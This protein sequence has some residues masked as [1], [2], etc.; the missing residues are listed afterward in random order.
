MSTA[1]HP[2]LPRLSLNVGVTGHR[3][4]DL[5]DTNLDT[6]RE[7]IRE[8]LEFLREFA[9]N[10]SEAENYYANPQK[11]MLRAISALAEG[12]DRHVAHQA[13]ALG[14]E[15]QCPL[16]FDRE[17]YAK[18]FDTEG[19]VLE[20]DT[21]LQHKNTTAVLELDG[22]RE[23]EADSYLAAGRVVLGQSDVLLTV[24]NG[25]VRNKKGGTSQIVAEA[26]QRNLPT[27]WINSDAPHNVYLRISDGKW[28][29]WAVGAGSLVIWLEAL[30][31]PPSRSKEDEDATTLFTDYFSEVQHVYNR[32]W[33]WLPFRNLCADGRWTLP[34]FLLPDFNQSGRDEWQQ[35]PEVA[36]TFSKETVQIMDA[37]NLFEHYG[38][39]DGLAGYY[40]NL[41][42]SAFV[43]NYLLGAVAVLF[44]F[45]HF[46][47]KEHHSID[48]MFTALELAALGSVAVIY[49]FGTK[50]RWHER[51]V[52]YRLL[53]EY[54]RQLFFL[55]PL[56]PGELSSPHIPAHMAAGDPRT[57]WM[58]W[59]YRAVRRDLG[60]I[61][62]RF[63]SAYL[64]SIRTFLGSKSLIG[65]QVEYH[66]NNARRFERLDRRFVWWIKS[67][68]VFA[69][70][71][72]VMALFPEKIA[73]WIRRLLPLSTLDGVVIVLAAIATVSP[74]VGAALAGI[75]SQGEFERVRKR[76]KAM[77]HWLKHI[78]DRLKAP[79]AGSAPTSS[80]AL[81]M[82]VAEAGQLM[83]DELL[84]WRIVFKDRPLP[85]PE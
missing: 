74:A 65:G 57:T 73:G 63:S 15:L 17:E 38:W 85:E 66:E 60:I 30:F 43:V 70:L 13:L 78:A 12:S 56:G 31:R 49:R 25:E 8:V 22:S 3:P 5:T 29:P 59:H 79:T 16:P 76:S 2:P 26:R 72:A 10:L 46:A 32:G 21:L 84:D 82:V 45:L 9:G 54:L 42:R 68:F 41:Y 48:W 14:F 58:H 64:E 23:R 36:A 39:A 47:F 69:I 37:A 62:A 34:S 77:H 67:L 75:R 53:A 11:P 80:D 27:I 28:N 40:G 51:W 6:L 52:D 4:K 33:L 81:S 19:S 71:A 61:R 7:K 44:A 50:G 20:F 18:D 35:V 55:T 1:E 83:V 24:W